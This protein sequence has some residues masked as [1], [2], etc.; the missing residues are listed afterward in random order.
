LLG[1][2]SWAAPALAFASDDDTGIAWA[3]SGV[4][5]FVTNGSL[6]MRFT[7]S[8]LQFG[9]MYIT[10]ASRFYNF[11]GTLPL[12]LGT[13]IT[14]SHGL[15]LND[16]ATGGSFE[17]DGSTYLDGEV[18]GIVEADLTAGACTAK[19]LVVDTGGANRENCRCNSA[20]TAYDCCTINAAPTCSTNG[21]VD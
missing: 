4:I 14:T 9:N 5:D 1:N 15:S 6:A 7:S 8:S 13:D 16:V 12:R 17:V 3:A 11:A 21:P 10:A 2:G 20:G 18:Y 19:R